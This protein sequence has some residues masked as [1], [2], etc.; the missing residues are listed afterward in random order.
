MA[1]KDIR[2]VAP[3]N[4]YPP[5]LADH[6]N[7]RSSSLRARAVREAL[8]SNISVAADMV[9]ESNDENNGQIESIEEVIVGLS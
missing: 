2:R 3:N 7:G 4:R 1:R 8:V 6:K 9:N 5:P